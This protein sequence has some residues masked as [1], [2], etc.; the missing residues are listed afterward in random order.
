MSKTCPEKNDSHFDVNFPSVF[1]LF[2]RFWVFLSDG[3]QKHYKKRFTKGRVEK[4]YKKIDQK[5]ETNFPSRFGAFLGKE[6]SNTP[7]K[8][9][10]K[11]S[12][13]KNK[14]EKSDKKIDVSFI[15]SIFWFYHVFSGVSK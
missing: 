2:S 15:A 1:F 11:K 4:F 12:M 8:Y 3:V 5:I 14:S 7:L 10:Y 6:R 13:S 9:V